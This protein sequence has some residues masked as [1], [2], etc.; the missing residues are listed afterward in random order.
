[1]PGWENNM[2]ATFLAVILVLLV[3]G[4][5]AA[6]TYDFRDAATFGAALNQPSFTAGVDGNKITITAAPDK[7]LLWWDSTDGIGV[8]YSSE[9]GAV[10]STGQLNIGFA[11]PVHIMGMLLTNL[12]D[13][14]S[15]NL[16]RGAYQLNGDG[17]WTKFSALPRQTP[18]NSNGELK[19][20]LDPSVSVS[21]ILFLVPGQSSYVVPGNELCVAMIVT[22]PPT[23]VPIPAAVWLLGSGLLGLVAIR[24]RFKK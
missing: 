22:D 13:D 5:A 21:S 12:F 10:V 17:N 2:K 16:V 11:V 7:A 9:G 14:G 6:S 19:L 23:S 4:T 20:M 8:Q 18:S 1:M 3:A 24:R 15:G